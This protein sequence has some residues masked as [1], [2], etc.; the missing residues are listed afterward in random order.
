VHLGVAPQN[1]RAIGFY[2]HVG[3]EDISRGGGVTFGLKFR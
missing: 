3:F 1:E 2:R